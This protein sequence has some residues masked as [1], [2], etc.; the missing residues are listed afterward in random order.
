MH[1]HREL[2]D[3]IWFEPGVGANFWVLMGTGYRENF[4]LCRSLVWTITTKFHIIYMTITTRIREI[5][6]FENWS[7]EIF[8][9]QIL[10]DRKISHQ[11]FLNSTCHCMVATMVVAVCK[12]SVVM[13]ISKIQPYAISEDKTF[14]VIEYVLEVWIWWAGVSLCCESLTCC[15]IVSNKGRFYANLY[16]RSAAP[17]KMA[18]NSLKWTKWQKMSGIDKFENKQ[19]LNMEQDQH[20]EVQFNRNSM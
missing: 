16:Q 11:K 8:Y 14:L 4:H 20:F 7:A 5:G 17:A 10:S 18:Q 19:T 9:W 3:I 15:W 13:I 6:I 1:I 2:T 12:R